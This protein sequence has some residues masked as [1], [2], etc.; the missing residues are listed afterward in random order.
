MRCSAKSQGCIFG[1]FG[2][3]NSIK[4]ALDSVCHGDYHV[5]SVPFECLN[6]FDE[7]EDRLERLNDNTI[8]V[9]AAGKS[10]TFQLLVVQDILL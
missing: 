3:I 5:L 2:D 9:A 6:E 1:D 7:I 8:I 4:Q 10:T